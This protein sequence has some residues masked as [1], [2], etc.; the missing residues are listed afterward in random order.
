LFDSIARGKPKYNDHAY[1]DLPIHERVQAVQTIGTCYVSM[2]PSIN[3]IDIEVMELPKIKDRMIGLLEALFLN[4]KVY[5]DTVICFEGF[6]HWI[7][8][9]L[10]TQFH[11]ETPEKNWEELKK[12]ILDN[13]LL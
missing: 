13:R 9:D 4:Y 5:E 8:V 2:R 11:L 6:N 12:F 3:L 10:K 1:L 7:M